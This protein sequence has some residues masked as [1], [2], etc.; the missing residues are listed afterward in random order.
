[1]PTAAAIRKKLKD[2]L[3][4][5]LFISIEDLGLVYDV[6][7]TDGAVHILMT[8]TTIGC[9]LFQTIEG[10]VRE[11]VMS[12]PGVTDVSIELTFDPPWDPSMMSDFAKAELGME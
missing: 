12:L 5:E 9:P 3:D 2:V 11:K 10:E 6:R 1:M 4:P 7:I 8:L